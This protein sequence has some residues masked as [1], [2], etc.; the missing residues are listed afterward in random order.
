MLRVVSAI[1]R[2][3]AENA[4]R[5]LQGEADANAETEEDKCVAKVLPQAIA[6]LP[7]VVKQISRSMP[8]AQQME[9]NQMAKA[10]QKSLS[11]RELGGIFQ[12][13]ARAI[14]EINK[15]LREDEETKK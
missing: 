5:G 3:D 14:Q 7:I 11:Q 15:A 8:D 13:T 4:R 12:L 6:M 2:G 10:V 9:L 1:A